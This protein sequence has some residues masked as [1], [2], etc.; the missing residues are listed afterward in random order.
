MNPAMLML[1][2]IRA[3]YMHE[4]CE[5][6]GGLGAE[7]WQHLLFGHGDVRLEDADLDMS[8]V[9]LAHFDLDYENAVLCQTW[10]HTDLYHP[11]QHWQ[12]IMLF[13]TAANAW[14]PEAIFGW[15]D[16]RPSF[17]EAGDVMD[18]F[19]KVRHEEGLL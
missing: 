8:I 17:M 1:G 4:A 9:R 11:G 15:G 18:S 5:Y 14:V 6:L 2:R 3:N 12:H 16:Y 19:L 7:N 10:Q 13:N